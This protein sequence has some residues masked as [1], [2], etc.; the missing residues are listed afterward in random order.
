MGT[1][2]RVD[3]R[4]DQ[5]LLHVASGKQI[6]RILVP[7]GNKV[8]ITGGGERS[9]A[10]GVQKPARAVIVHYNPKRD[11]KQG[12]AGEAATIEFR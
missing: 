2:Q 12:T 4:G 10:C 3:C 9:L 7:D 8:E 1:L 6:T 11:S 5:A